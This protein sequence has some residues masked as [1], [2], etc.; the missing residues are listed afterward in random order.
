MAFFVS[1]NWMEILDGG[2]CVSAQCHPPI[3]SILII[4][5]ISFWGQKVPCSTSTPH[6]APVT[7]S[8]RS[9]GA[10]RVKEEEK[11]QSKH[12]P[13]DTFGPHRIVCHQL[14]LSHPRTP[15]KVRTSCSPIHVNPISHFDFSTNETIDTFALI[16]LGWN[17]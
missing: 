9:S 6:Q 2:C 13:T 10:R 15:K 3:Q 14:L 5:K 8:G 1:R 16:L 17:R 7:A 4:S 12:S 11:K